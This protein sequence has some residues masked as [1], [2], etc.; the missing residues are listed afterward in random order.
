MLSRR[1]DGADRSLAVARAVIS[2]FPSVFQDLSP[3]VDRQ[4]LEAHSRTGAT[5]LAALSAPHSAVGGG[6]TTTA[7]RADS[8][9][10]DLV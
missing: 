2:R 5:A 9:Q 6:A 3:H 8:Y 10:R 1:G 7:V 4:T